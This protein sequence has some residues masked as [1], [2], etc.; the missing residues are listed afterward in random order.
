MFCDLVVGCRPG[1]VSQF[2]IPSKR[3]FVDQNYAERFKGADSS[4]NL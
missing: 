3:K 1:L 2:L 4:D